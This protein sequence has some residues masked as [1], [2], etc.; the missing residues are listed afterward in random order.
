MKI[1]FLGTGTSQGVPVIG[2]DCE[3]CQSSDIRDKRLRTSTMI[4]WKEKTIVIDV[5]PDFRQQLLRAKVT[6][7]DA[8]L[9]THEHNDHIIGMDDVRPLNFKYNKSMPVY[10]EKRVQQELKERFAYIFAE[11]PYP[12]APR[13]I[14]EN[15]ETNKNIIIENLTIQ[16]IRAWHGQLPVFGFRFEDFTY[17]TDVNK[18]EPLE[19]EKVKGTKI[20]ALD[21]LHHSKHH[22]HFNLEEALAFIEI[23]Q[24]E[25]AYLIHISHRMGLR[26][27]V[28]A[29]LPPNVQLAFDGLILT[30]VCPKTPLK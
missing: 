13:L 7:V 25:Q 17:L 21:A 6:D 20:L 18:L 26:E 4:E 2:C 19:I 28:N 5:G 22:S 27:K 12:G 23:I 24:P 16:P 10:A 14:L 1:T 3:V 30:S 11:N 29:I 8:I 15:I 9:M